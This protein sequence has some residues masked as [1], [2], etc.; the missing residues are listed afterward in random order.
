MLIQNRFLATLIG[1]KQLRSPEAE[2]RRY[3]RAH[4]F[5]LFVLFVQFLETWIAWRQPKQSDQELFH[6]LEYVLK[7]SIIYLLLQWMSNELSHFL[8]DMQILCKYWLLTFQNFRQHVCNHICTFQLLL[9]C[10]FC[11]FPLF[12]SR[13]WFLTLIYSYDMD[14]LQKNGS[15]RPF[16]PEIDA[17]TF[18][19][20]LYR[21]TTACCVSWQIPKT[22]Q[23]NLL[24]IINGSNDS[25]RFFE[26]SL[27]S[28]RY[29]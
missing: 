2:L 6:L 4:T 1:A 8:P 21:V 27:Y 5:E 10:F 7:K 13:F 23:G 22:Q 24:N 12:W 17:Q 11:V 3:L 29:L 19:Y 9:S 20:T 28:T 26:P 18:W 15:K 16:L 25:I 14:I